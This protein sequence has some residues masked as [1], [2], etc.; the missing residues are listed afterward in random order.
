MS[1]DATIAEAMQATMKADAKAW[2]R[3]RRAIDNIA[4]VSNDNAML[5]AGGD[6]KVFEKWED[7]KKRRKAEREAAASGAVVKAPPL[8][9]VVK[10]RGATFEGKPCKTCGGR[11]RYRSSRRCVKCKLASSRKPIAQAA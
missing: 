8:V 3:R 9:P 7:R 5:D 11:L 6:H 2:A 10:P 4:G 1:D